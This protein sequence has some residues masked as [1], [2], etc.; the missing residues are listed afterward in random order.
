[1]VATVT[2]ATISVTASNLFYVY[3]PLSK[4]PNVHHFLIIFTFKN[5][6]IL[7]EYEQSMNLDVTL[8]KVGS[9]FKKQIKLKFKTQKT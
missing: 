7:F 6:N 2:D 3:T 8:N 4:Q 1:M 9:S 5:L